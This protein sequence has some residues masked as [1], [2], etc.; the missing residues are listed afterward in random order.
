MADTDTGGLNSKLHSSTGRRA[1]G[2]DIGRH[3][4]RAGRATFRGRCVTLFKY[5]R[6]SKVVIYP[7]TCREP[8]ISKHV[9]SLSTLC[10]GT[11]SEANT[12]TVVIY[13]LCPSLVSAFQLVS[14]RLVGL[15]LSKVPDAIGRHLWSLKSLSFSRCEPPQMVQQRTT[16]I[17]WHK[18]VDIK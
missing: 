5:F 2:G 4:W 14:L 12:T 9:S 17:A 6:S 16:G 15:G 1:G 11:T 13:I 3:G 8:R 7:R 18:S 10:A